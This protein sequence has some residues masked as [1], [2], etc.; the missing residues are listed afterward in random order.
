MLMSYFRYSKMLT[1]G[2]INRQRSLWITSKPACLANAHVVEVGLQHIS[3]AFLI[4]GLGVLTAM[5]IL[6]LE[7]LHVK[8]TNGMHAKN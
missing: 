2:I 3:P 8:C 5:L 1:S 4:L 7:L 6:L